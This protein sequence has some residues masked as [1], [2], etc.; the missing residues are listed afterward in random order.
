MRRLAIAAAVV[1][2]AAA[3]AS[4]AGAVVRVTTDPPLDKPFARAAPDYVS[5]CAPGRPL[6]ISVEASGGERVSVAGRPARAGSFEEDVDRRAGEAV[7]L[8]VESATRPGSYPVRCL[9]GDFPHWLASRHGTPQSQWFVA[10][11]NGYLLKGYVAIF[12]SRATP[13]WWR[14][15]G[16]YGPWDGKLMP[17]GNVAWTHFEGD[18]FGQPHARGYEERDL[19][20][21]LVRRVRAVGV[22]TDTHELQRLPGGHYLV[23]SYVRRE[24]VDLRRY[25]GPRHATVYDGEIQELTAAGRRVWRWSTRDH[26]SLAETGRWWRYLNHDQARKETSERYWDVAHVNSVEPDGQRLILSFRHLDAVFAIDRRSG[27]VLWKLGG[28]KRPES[29]RVVGDPYGARPFGGQHDARLYRDGTLTVYDNEANT[30]RPPRAVR[31]RIDAHARTATLVE[32]VHAPDPKLRSPF[33][34]SARKLPAGN[35]MVYWGGTTLVT[36]QRPSGRPVLA[37]D[38]VHNRWG[39]RAV[40]VPRGTLSASELRRGMDAMVSRAP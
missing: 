26:V 29:L 21:R 22:P 24:G 30:T 6:T 20:G 31:F 8:R 38:F 2:A 12:D 40:P 4:P 28:T 37:A 7:T 27:R 1:A 10:T 39:Y 17:G 34:G 25:G 3:A 19:A 11:P 13:V 14:H 23:D 5:R 36:E 9:P 18:P 32:R 15:A 35:W 16:E 33:A